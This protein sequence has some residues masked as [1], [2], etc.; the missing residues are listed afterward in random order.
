MKITI[1][2]DKAKLFNKLDIL[3]GKLFTISLFSYFI[4]MIY[5]CINIAI[6]RLN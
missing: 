5:L 1:E 3:F 4:Y 2:I 6:K